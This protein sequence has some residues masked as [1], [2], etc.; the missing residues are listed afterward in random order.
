MNRT[1]QPIGMHRPSLPNTAYTRMAPRFI[2]VLVLVLA[3][4]VRLWR[5]RQGLP[6][7][8]DEAIPFKQAL[9]MWGWDTGRVDLNP[10]F[11]S[12]PTFAIYLHFLAQQVHCALGVAIGQFGNA[13][14]YSVAI[15][16]DP[17]DAVMVARSLGVA[18]DLVSVWMSWRIAES[19][20]KGTGLIAAS[21][22]ALSP[23]LVVT[24]RAV[25]VDTI[26]AALA[27]VAVERLVAWQ[28][29]GGRA[30]LCLAIAFMGLAAGSKYPGGLLVIPLAWALWSRAGWRGLRLWPLA[31]AASA[32]VFALSSPWVVLDFRSFMTGFGA[33][34][35]HMQDGHLGVLHRTGGAHY[36]RLL[37]SDPGPIALALCFHQAVR[38]RRLPIAQ[39][40]TITLLATIAPLMAVLFAVRMEAD[41]YLVIALP[42][43]AA[44][45]AVAA[46]DV[47]ARLSS[48]VLRPLLIVAV[49]LPV[50]VGG[51]RVLFSG[52]D[53][54]QQEARR[55]CEEHLSDGGVLVQEAYGVKLATP[56]KQEAILRQRYFQLATP[57]MRARLE[58]RKLYRVVSIPMA[59][60]GRIGVQVAGRGGGKSQVTVFA[61]AA[62]I[63]RIFYDP[64]LYRGVDYL[65]V[66]GAMRQRYLAEPDRFAAQIDFYRHLDARASVAVRFAPRSGVT[67]PEIVIYA[68]GENFW[69]EDT[70]ESPGLDPLWW[71]SAVPAAYVDHVS[72]LPGVTG[73]V[74]RAGAAGPRETVAPWIWSLRPV[75]GEYVLPFALEIGMYLAN[76]GKLAEAQGFASTVLH[77][78]PESD[79]GA[80]LYSYCAVRLGDLAGAH[81]QVSLTL[82]EQQRLG[83]DAANMS[84]E[85][86]RIEA[87]AAKR[88]AGVSGRSSESRRRSERGD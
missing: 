22:I 41:R 32:G 79:Q 45:A 78:V 16:L 33:E 8:V 68:L 48:R 69:R 31:A 7:F 67:G 52:R 11:F 2:L 46:A 38:L 42:M 82:L 27:A 75:F 4:V 15:D 60:S 9:E 23:T 65:L 55:W 49:V 14:D 51:T 44:L 74:D 61:Q 84:E 10:H 3:A 5:L 30:R 64:R 57:A 43:I 36:A 59:S 12:Y 66:S 35:L 26:A 17:S 58:E 88:G 76:R 37:M 6:D 85:L 40:T 53:S 81:R 83:L 28:R 39:G 34:F 47:S 71:T 87:L 1:G 18:A 73:Y 54:T 77:V 20:R 50:A 72:A 70:S 63:N 25:H 62:D 19:I 13:A 29:S 24:A 86:R 56:R 21:I 80:Q